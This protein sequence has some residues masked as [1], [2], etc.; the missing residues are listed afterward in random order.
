MKN[1]VLGV[2]AFYHDSSAVLIGNGRVLCA[3]EE[4]RFSRIKHDNGFPEKAIKFCLESNGISFKDVSA[5]AYY[6]KPL[7]KFERILDTFV[8]TYPKSLIPFVD[9]MPE[10][11]GKKINIE[12]EIR[13]IGFEGDIYYVPHHFSHAAATFFNSGFKSA[14]VL[15]VDGV[16]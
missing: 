13:N 8:S 11:L 7:K 10:W 15:T 1:Y 12:Q 14:S 4:K 3:A 2:S 5:V 9:S 16:W 6:E